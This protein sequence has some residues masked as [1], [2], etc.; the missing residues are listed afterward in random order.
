MIDPGRSILIAAL[1]F[2]AFSAGEARATAICGPGTHW[3]DTCLGDADF[4]PSTTAVVTTNI[5]GTINL[6]GPT[7]IVRQD[8]SDFSIN[9]PGF[10]G[11]SLDGHMD[12]IDTEIVALSLT[13]GPFV[14]TAG[15]GVT[16]GGVILSP[17][18]GVIVEDPTDSTLALSHFELFFE[19]DLTAL[20]PGLYLY[21]HDP[22]IMEAVID[23][24]PPTGTHVPP[25]PGP[26]LLYDDPVAGS[27]IAQITDSSHTTVGSV[28]EPASAVLLAIGL[29]VLGVRARR[30][31]GAPRR[32]GRLESYA[33]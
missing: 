33:R 32:N 7:T 24:V 20:V 21:N 31:C 17:S 9:F 25:A 18:L 28:P 19:L 15:Q 1:V 13:G 29:A 30:S 5:A 22:H 16:P 23:G 10:N 26:T 2:A 6:A 3:M 27:V 8:A 12:V 11:S 4:F 14:L